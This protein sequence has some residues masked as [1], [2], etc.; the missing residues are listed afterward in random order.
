M[1]LVVNIFLKEEEWKKDPHGF[2][3]AYSPPFLKQQ[4]NKQKERKPNALDLVRW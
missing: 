1:N 4:T 3:C 2:I